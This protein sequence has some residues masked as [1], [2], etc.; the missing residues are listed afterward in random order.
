MLNI[1]SHKDKSFFEKINEII[2][3]RQNFDNEIKDK[4][5]EIILSIKEKGDDILF[6][7]IKKYD[8]VECDET[9]IYY[10]K[11]DIE[12]AIKK[13][14]QESINAIK[15]AKERI[16]NFLNYQMPSESFFEDEDS[17]RIKTRWIPLENA[18]IYIPG[19]TASYP[20]SVLMGVIPAKIAGVSNIV[21][22]VPCPNNE[23]D[24][25]VL[26][27]LDICG[28][29]KIYKI[30]GAQAIAALTW[31]TESIGKV[32]II[33]GP[34][35]KWV[36]EAKKQVI[37]DVQIDMLA[38]P[39]EIMII[40]DKN[41]KADWV[42]SDLLSQ[43]EHDV[44]S[45]AILITDD[46]NFL[47]AVNDQITTQLKLLNRS[48]I[49][50]KSI[51]ENG[52]GILVNNIEDAIEIANTISPEHLSILC[53]EKENIEKQIRNAGVIFSD[54]WTPESMGDYI[55]GPS[56]ILPTIGTARN[57]SGLSVFNFL[58]R[59][60]TLSSSETA[61]KKL[62]PAAITLA[63]CEGLD[64]HANSIKLRIKD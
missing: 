34:G 44:S 26:A 23:I 30:G 32:D 56:H 39:S 57:Q 63:E 54:E 38:G 2:S 1:V 61:I 52:C 22:T 45:Q 49:I 12:E 8:N 6:E 9:N 29:E 31:G 40:A 46:V 48:E 28:V 37:G 55:I 27:T 18:G 19:G 58:R 10:S 60:S 53:S 16:E 36:A 43:A 41:N 7:Y 20:S 13:C 4:V 50:S 35:N 24:P 14:N 25:L 21:A 51:K 3:S 64:A 15:I 62:G 5:R 42:A 59:Q 11:N 47:D 17:I 33:V